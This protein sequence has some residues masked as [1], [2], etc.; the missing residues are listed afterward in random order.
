MPYRGVAEVFMGTLL[1]NSLNVEEV[2]SEQGKRC[3]ECFLDPTVSYDLKVS[4]DPAGGP[5]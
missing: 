2:W 3:Q 4:S 5:V 1:D